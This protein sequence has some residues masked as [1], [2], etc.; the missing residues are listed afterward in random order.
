MYWH[1]MWKREGRPHNSFSSYM[2]RKTRLQ[3]HYAVRCI[4]KN[5]DAIRSAKMAENS[6][7][8]NKDLWVEAKK[9]RGAHNK[10]PLMVDGITG[11]ENISKGLAEKFENLYNSVGYDSDHLDKIKST[12][13]AH[14]NSHTR[15]ND[16]Q[17]FTFILQIQM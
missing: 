16:T 14:I 5:K 12:I 10:L 13:D 2:R 3:Y 7:N 6:L 1:D 8:N 4:D 17:I 11:D 9:S 15:G